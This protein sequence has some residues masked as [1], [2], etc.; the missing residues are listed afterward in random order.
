M[1]V[2]KACH[3]VGTL[4][5]VSTLFLVLSMSSYSPGDPTDNSFGIL[6]VSL[7]LSLPIGCYRHLGAR[8]FY[9]PG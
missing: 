3:V 5:V 4:L 7:G 6:V 1:V 8:L 2:R 9:W